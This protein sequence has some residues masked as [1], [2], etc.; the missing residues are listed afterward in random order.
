[1]QRIAELKRAMVEV[2]LP[3]LDAPP[4]YSSSRKAR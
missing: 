4:D 2:E 1:M 3:P